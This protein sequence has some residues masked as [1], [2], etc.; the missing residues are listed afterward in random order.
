VSSDKSFYAFKEGTMLNEEIAQRSANVGCPYC[1]Q[2][3][4]SVEVDSECLEFHTESGQPCCHLVYAEWSSFD[5]ANDGKRRGCKNGDFR[6]DALAHAASDYLMDLMYESAR[7]SPR[8][9]FLVKT[10]WHD[11]IYHDAAYAIDG[12]PDE[13]SATAEIRALFAE[14][15][16]E[17][18]AEVM[19]I[20]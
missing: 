15:P 18:V 6:A 13:R 5:G 2:G 9:A 4:L 12:E 14:N 11:S 17:F 20:R 3:E 16:D 8:S 1:E 19:R 10:D 7:P